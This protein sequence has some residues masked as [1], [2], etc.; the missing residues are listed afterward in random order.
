MPEANSLNQ[1]NP[2]NAA[3]W[4]Y[5]PAA[6]AGIANTTAVEIKAADTGVVNYIDEITVGNNSAVATVV[7]I[8][9]AS[10]VIARIH[11]PAQ[12]PGYRHVFDPPLASAAG[13][14]LNV[15]AVTTSAALLVIA[16]GH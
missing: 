9:S 3:D 8:L 4:R 7:Q 16:K 13:E 11:A 15:K 6:D 12:S 14:A 2:S 1:S 10:T 5:V